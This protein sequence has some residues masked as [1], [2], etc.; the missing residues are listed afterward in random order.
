MAWE[1]GFDEDVL[2]NFVEFVNIVEVAMSHTP[3]CNDDLALSLKDLKGFMFIM[4]QPKFQGAD[5]ASGN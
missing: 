3:K 1:L 2:E 5:C 4:I